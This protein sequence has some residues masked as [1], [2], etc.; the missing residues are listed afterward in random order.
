M[1]DDILAIQAM[2]G[3]D[4]TTRGQATNAYGFNANVDLWLFDFTQNAHPVVCIYD[5]GGI[6]T[7]NLSGWNTACVINLAPGSFSNA[8]MMTYNISIARNTWIE[9]AVDGGRG[10]DLLT[11]AGGEDVFIYAA[12][13]GADV[14]TD[15]I[16]TGTGA[17]LI[18]LTGYQSIT[19]YSALLAI[20][21]QSGSNTVFTFSSGNSLTLQGV[22][23]ATLAATDFVFYSGSTP[24]PLDPPPT[25]TGVTITGTSGSD[26]IDGTR[27]PSGQPF[28][29]NYNDTIS[30]LAGNDVI[31]GL[32]GDDTIEGGSGTDQVNGGNGNDKFLVSGSSNDVSDTFNGG[33]GTDTLQVT[34]TGRSRSA[35]STPQPR[36]SNPGSATARRCSATPRPTPSISPGS[37]RRAA[38]PM[39]TAAAA[40]TRSG[41]ARRCTIC[42]AAAAT[43]PLSGGDGDDT[44]TGGS[45]TD[46]MSGGGGNDR[47][48]V[49]G[50]DAASDTFN[51]G[52]GT[53]TLQVTG[54]GSLSLNGFNATTASIETWQGN[55]QAVTGSAAANAFNFGGLTWLL[56]LSYVD[57]GSGNDTL[58]G[59][60]FADDLRGGSGTDRLTG[61]GG[62]DTLRGTRQRHVHIRSGIRAGQDHGLCAERDERRRDPVQRGNV[63]QLHGRA[64]CHA[65]GRLG[66]RD[67][68]R[69]RQHGHHR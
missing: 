31:S 65:T 53:D 44:L 50:S 32:D 26:T 10:N 45:G 62:N 38:C 47:F 22:S 4:L 19:S 54:S 40:T 2:Y 43:T 9:N 18:D 23:L 8:D 24:P 34:G 55:G 58:V 16:V 6:D 15:F 48:L 63:C 29:T 1:M 20:G 13:Y 7:L 14:I 57:G 12:S 27:A 5:A 42:A 64:G 66:R 52:A 28:A 46:N 61:G 68:A 21:N 49:S 39:S 37:R 25:G 17:D 11:G 51:G 30:G 59:S 36:R 35:A 41:A 69:R 33:A 60:A 3:A 67:H 56:G